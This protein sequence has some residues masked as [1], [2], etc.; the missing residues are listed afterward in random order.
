MDQSFKILDQRTHE[1]LGQCVA[2]IKVAEEELDRE[3]EEFLR[4]KRF[5]KFVEKY[6]YINNIKTYYRNYDYQDLKL[7]SEWDYTT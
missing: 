1:C 4:L 6:K 2:Q 3:I 5:E 7:K